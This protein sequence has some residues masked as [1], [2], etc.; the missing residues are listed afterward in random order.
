MLPYIQIMSLVEL[1]KMLGLGAVAVALG[2]EGLDWLL[3]RCLWPRRVSRQPLK[4]V[5]FF[6]SPPAC[7]E[8]L[9]NPG[10]R[11]PC[12]CPLPHGL[13]TPFSRLLEHLLSVCVSLDLCL[14]NF[15]NA[16]LSRAV[17]LLHSQ[18]VRVRVLVD[19]D[20]MATTG[21][22]IGV[23]RKA[24]QMYRTARSAS[25]NPEAYTALITPPHNFDMFC[26]VLCVYYDCEQCDHFCKS[27]RK[28]SV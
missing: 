12:L 25:E 2:L 14:F 3:T 22:Q 19:R 17:L 10:S 9:Y 28:V 16:E 23:L 15:S 18:G 26:L 6:P 11:H 20:Y 21:S 4:E 27:E 5:L 1:L 24:V 7:V 8:H 13:N